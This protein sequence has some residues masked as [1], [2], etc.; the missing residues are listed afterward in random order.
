MDNLKA[1]IYLIISMLIFGTIGIFVR[2][3]PFSSAEIAFFRG[4]IGAT[5]L[6]VILALKGEKIK[7]EALKKSLPILC[8]SGAFIGIN[9]ILLFEAYRH[10]TVATA[11]LCYYMAPVIVITVSVFLFK[12]RLTLKK[13]FCAVAAVVGMVFVS[14]VLN[15]EFSVGQLK[16]VLLGLGA[17]VF[18]ALVIILNKKLGLIPPLYK[19]AF[20]LGS[21]ALVILPY[22]LVRHTSTESHITAVSVILLAVVGIVHTGI[23]YT[24]YFSAV[25]RLKAQTTAVLSYIDPV[26]AIILSGTVLKENMGFLSVIGAV[27]ILGAALINELPQ[28]KK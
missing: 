16:G 5:F 28:K 27:I 14:G 2:Y 20:Q 4:A 1:K 8:L 3:I 12:E 22:V 24:L 17:A 15:S 19:T 7:G 18:Y 25:G 23:A 21:A 10:T 9:W 26:I 11:T 6:A 13:L